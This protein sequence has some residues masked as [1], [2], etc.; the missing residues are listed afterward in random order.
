MAK[1]TP[2]SLLKNYLLNSSF[3]GYRFVIEN[4]RHWTERLFWIVC[5]TLSWVATGLLIYSAYDDFKNNAISFVV[6][7]SYLDWDTNFPSVVVCETDQQENIANVTDKVFGDPHDY[8]LDEIVKELVYYKGLSI[9]TLQICGPDVQNR[10]ENCFKKHLRYFHDQVRSSCRNLFKSCIWDRREFDCCKYFRIIDTELGTCY[11][12]NSLQTREAHPPSFKMV[13]N[14]KLGPGSLKL[15]LLGNLNLYVLGPLDVPSLSS[16]LT[17]IITVSPNTRIERY[18]AIKEIE[19]QPEVKHVEIDKRK[20]R[21]PEETDFDVYR[22]YSYSACSVR[23]RKRA[24]LSK[25]RCAHHLV[26]NTPLENQCDLDGIKCLNDNYNE[27]SVFKAAW[28]NRTGLVCGCLPSC[29]EIEVTVIRDDKK[30]IEEDYAI[31][32]LQLDRLP[33]ERFKRNVVRGKLDLVVSMGGAT[34]LFL[35]ASLL[36]FVEILHYLVVTPCAS[37]IRNTIKP[38]KKSLKK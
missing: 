32:D 25:C 20:C 18:F 30:R 5:C 14:R 2:K 12:I 26:P 31:V 24:Q 33:T 19:N 38:P 4:N 28:S 9:Y 6:D 15:K 11:G 23:C 1:K 7:T 3:H 22:Y 17:D 10:D 27:I 8:N 36:S 13:S 35:G 29:N 16:S 37:Y 34:A 21:F